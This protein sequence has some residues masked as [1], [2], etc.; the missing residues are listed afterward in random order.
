MFGINSFS[1]GTCTA[2]ANTIQK[3]PTPIVSILK[4]VF[5]SSTCSVVNGPSY[6]DYKFS[7]E[8]MHLLI[9]LKVVYVLIIFISLG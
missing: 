1:T 8:R 9:T 7:L 6:R 3:K 4:N 2:N 5:T